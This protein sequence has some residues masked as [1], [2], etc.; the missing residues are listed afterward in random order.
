MYIFDDTFEDIWAS[1]FYL[2][3][4]LTR[5][6]LKR[7]GKNKPEGKVHFI[8]NEEFQR[9]GAL[10]RLILFQEHFSFLFHLWRA[11]QSTHK[12]PRPRP[13][14]HRWW[15]ALHFSMTQPPSYIYSPSA[16]PLILTRSIPSPRIP[17]ERWAFYVCV[18]DCQSRED[19]RHT[20]AS[21][22]VKS[23]SNHA[24]MSNVNLCEA[25]GGVFHLDPAVVQWLAR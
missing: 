22:A 16:W 25:T 17:W 8:C 9:S 13:K 4:F 14:I 1:F 23:G 2:F 19:K 10:S 20:I 6:F 18:S 11:A 24:W 15:F 5:E 12:P 3:I 21:V 7:E